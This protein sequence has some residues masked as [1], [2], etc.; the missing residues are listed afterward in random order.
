MKHTRIVL[1][2]GY[3]MSITY[4]IAWQALDEGKGE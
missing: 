4:N 2:E 3:K 1:P